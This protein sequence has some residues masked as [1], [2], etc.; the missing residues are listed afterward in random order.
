M[1]VYTNERTLECMKNITLSAQDEKIDML[2]QLAR[3]SGKTVNELFREWLDSDIAKLEASQRQ[4]QSKAFRESVKQFSFKSERKYTR[5][6]M[7]ER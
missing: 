2:R 1:T 3:S 7:N 5:E 6:E 4:K